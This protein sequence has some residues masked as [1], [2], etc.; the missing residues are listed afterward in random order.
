MK[1]SPSGRQTVPARLPSP[2]PRTPENAMTTI[3]VP[4]RDDVSPANQAIFDNLKKALG[5][6]PNLYATMALSEHALGNYTGLPER[7]E[8]HHR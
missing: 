1:V 8:Q 6:V 2:E 5:T 4:T 7:E 3:T